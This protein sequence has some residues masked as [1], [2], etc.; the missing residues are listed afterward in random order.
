[1]SGDFWLGVAFVP[2]ALLACFLTYCAIRWLVHLAGLAACTLARI[3][4]ET[5]ED[6]RATLGA[7]TYS[8]D[9]VWILGFGNVG[10]AFFAGQTGR[11]P[12]AAFNRLRQ[13]R[14]FKRASE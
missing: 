5:N 10:V 13:L 12:V 11:D 14:E 6:T 4:P 9:R 3:A 7:I 1:M 2:A 8:A